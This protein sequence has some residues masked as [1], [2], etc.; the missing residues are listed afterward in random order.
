MAQKK[1]WWYKFLVKEATNRVQPF[2]ADK[3]YLLLGRKIF[4]SPARVHIG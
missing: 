1:G 3:V 4:V 2:E